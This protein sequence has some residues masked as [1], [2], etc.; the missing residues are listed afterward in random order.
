MHKADLMEKLDSK[1]M[2][3]PKKRKRDFRVGVDSY[4]LR[5]VNLRNIKKI[6]GRREF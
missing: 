1:A 6:V 2:V 5:P 4:S 3:P